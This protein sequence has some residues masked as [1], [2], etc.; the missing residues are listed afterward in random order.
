M[1]FFGMDTFA[2]AV[3]PEN[4]SSPI[5]NNVFGNDTSVMPLQS[6]NALI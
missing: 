6:V 3:Q 4:A 1:V 2:S 5:L